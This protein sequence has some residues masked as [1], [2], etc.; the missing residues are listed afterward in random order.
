MLAHVQGE[1]WEPTGFGELLQAGLVVQPSAFSL[2]ASQLA[3]PEFREGF[4]DKERHLARA[5]EPVLVHPH[6]FP[7]R[8]LRGHVKRVGNV[9]SYR[10]WMLTAS[11]VYATTIK[12]D[13]PFEGLKPGMTADV[14]ILADKPL[15]HVLTAPVEAVLGHAK[16]GDPGTCFVL[17]SDGPEQRDIAVGLSNETMIEV[18]TGL[19]EGEEVVLNPLTLLNERRESETH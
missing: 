18:R 5:G 1:D 12:L 2:L 16:Q 7:G 15:E 19:R 3:F 4:R 6:A 13:E 10:E 11:K 9:A 17:T 8:V 14:T